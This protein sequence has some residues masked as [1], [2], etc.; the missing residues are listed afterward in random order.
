MGFHTQ[1][2]S[3]CPTTIS[4]PDL[5]PLSVPLLD[6]TIHSRLPKSGS[7]LLLADMTKVLDASM[8]PPLRLLSYLHITLAPNDITFSW[9]LP[10]SG[11]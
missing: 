6:E 9:A 3:L 10:T 2:V 1:G 5:L 7:A 8:S 11:L 4:I